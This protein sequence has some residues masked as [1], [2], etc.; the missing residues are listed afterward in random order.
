MRIN[1]RYFPLVIVTAV[2]LALRAQTVDP[3][4]HWQGSISVPSRPI[5]I[6]ID[7]QKNAKGELVGTLSNAAQNVSGLPLAKVSVEGKSL[8]LFLTPA[9]GGGTFDG[10]LSDDRLSF[11]GKFNTADGAHTIPFLLT[12]TGDAKIEAAPKSPPIGKEFE[13]TWNGA[14]AVNGDLRRLVLTMSNQP[15]GTSM[16]TILSVDGGG[17]E[18]PVALDVKGPLLTVT[19]KMVAGSFA[20]TLSADGKSIDGTWTEG[21]ATFPLTFK[22]K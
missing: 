3:S 6:E 17:I 2:P 16:G 22:K 19:V 4:G 20:G 8:H 21:I 9:T 11:E 10:L 1:R 18:A 12:R 5:A 13:G 14:L 15:D 7:L